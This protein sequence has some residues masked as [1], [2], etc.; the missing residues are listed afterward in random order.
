MI[1]IPAEVDEQRRAMTYAILSQNVERVR[2]LVE[3]DAAYDEDQ[4][5]CILADRL[6]TPKGKPL[7]I[8]RSLDI[9]E[10]VGPSFAPY[11]ESGEGQGHFQIPVSTLLLAADDALYEY[12]RQ[13]IPDFCDHFAIGGYPEIATTAIENLF[14]DVHVVK[15]GNQFVPAQTWVSILQAGWMLTAPGATMAAS[16]P[17]L[18]VL[19]FTEN[20]L[21]AMVTS[22][23]VKAQHFAV[24]E[25]SY[26]SGSKETPIE[27]SGTVMEI[28]KRQQFRVRMLLRFFEEFLP[29]AM[30]DMDGTQKKRCLELLTPP[31]GR[32]RPVSLST[33]E[34]QR[35]PAGP[36]WWK[37]YRPS[38]ALE[39]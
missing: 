22:V 15:A 7:E 27:D 24:V 21:R 12:N 16:V 4:I 2:Q 29:R 9:I 13:I 19:S 20:Q 37:A 10:I 5:R 33:G 8:Q 31:E 30:R 35:V 39:I 3:A 11:V 34:P 17:P 23:G 14:S 32:L 25:R 1:A 38:G 18:D 6:T 26:W 36:E 28:L